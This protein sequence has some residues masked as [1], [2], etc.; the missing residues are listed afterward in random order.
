MTTSIDDCIALQM[1]LLE[2][3]DARLTQEAAVAAAQ[4]AVAAAPAGYKTLLANARLRDAIAALGP[5]V[6]EPTTEDHLMWFANRAARITRK[7][8]A[9]D[10]GRTVLETALEAA[11][12]AGKGDAWKYANREIK[13]NPS[14]QAARKCLV[15]ADAAR[16]AFLSRNKCIL[17]TVDEYRRAVAPMEERMAAILAER[18]ELIRSCEKLRIPEGTPDQPDDSLCPEEPEEWISIG[19]YLDMRQ[20]EEERTLR[21]TERQTPMHRYKMAPP[22]LSPTLRRLLK[23]PRCWPQV[24]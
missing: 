3:V 9:M 5:E 1:T 13:E 23:G 10:V 8:A 12:E 14:I 18:E 16:E 20:K 2:A 6:S 11:I 17:D 7:L 19:D 24:A 21:L 15:E 22:V 4:A